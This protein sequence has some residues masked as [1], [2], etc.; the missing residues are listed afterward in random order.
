MFKKRFLGLFA[1]IVALLVLASASLVAA[2]GARSGT[3]AVVTGH[4]FMS[5]PLSAFGIDSD[6]N[7]VMDE[8]VYH[9]ELKGDGTVSGSYS[10]QITVFGSTNSYSGRMF[11]VKVDGNR[12]WIGATVDAT[13]HPDRLGLYS[14]WQVADNSGDGTADH[15]TFLGFGTEQETID[16]CEGPAPNFI[17]NIDRG[18]IAVSD[19]Q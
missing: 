17:F 18:N 11:C 13:T 5:V 19:R 2:N 14:W 9:A 12:A 3:V 15:S 10:Y 6:E 1:A 16:Y 8:L 7:A 4:T